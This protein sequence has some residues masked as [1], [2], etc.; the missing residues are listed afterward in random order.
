MTCCAARPR[1]SAEQPK[2]KNPHHFGRFASVNRSVFFSTLAS[3]IA[4]TVFAPAI[5]LFAIY[6]NEIGPKTHRYLSHKSSPSIVF[7]V[8]FRP[9]IECTNF[10]M[11]YLLSFVIKKKPHISINLIHFTQLLIDFLCEIVYL[12]WI[13][14]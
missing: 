7:N 10:D 8:R 12:W 3:P 2:Q 13:H 11:I 1:T 14:Q 9:L 4:V 5:T 6:C